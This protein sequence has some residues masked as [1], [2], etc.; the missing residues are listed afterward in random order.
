[1]NQISESQQTPHS[2][3]SRA[4][5]GVS[6]V[7]IWEKIDCI[8]TALHCTFRCCCNT[9]QYVIFYQALHWHSRYQTLIS[10]KTPHSSP[11]W[12]N[13]V[14]FIVRIWEKTDQIYQHSIALTH[15]GWDKMDTISQMAFSNAC[16]W[17]KTHKFRLRFHWSLF[18]RFELII[19]SIGSDNGLAPARRQAIIWTNDG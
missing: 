19:S 6:I 4:S 15:W 10:Q 5:Y 3:P 17:M 13:Y 7:R 9:V 11:S 1:M 18:L 8:I 16:S 12:L 14:V 2:L